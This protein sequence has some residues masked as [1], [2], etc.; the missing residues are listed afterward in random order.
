MTTRDQYFGGYFAARY[1]PNYFPV[2]AGAA[3]DTGGGGRKRRPR[4]SW[5]EEPAEPAAD[6]IALLSIFLHTIDP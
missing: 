2:V 6:L 5:P 1:L 3:T 4:R